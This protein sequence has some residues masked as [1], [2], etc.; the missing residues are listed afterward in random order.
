MNKVLTFII[1]KDEN[2]Q[3]IIMD[4]EVEENLT[5]SLIN[6]AGKVIPKNSLGDTLI[7]ISRELFQTMSN[8]KPMDLTSK[9]SGLSQAEILKQ[10]EN[11]IKD[12]KI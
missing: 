2:R 10:V 4:I 12:G 6:I 11:K 8:N 7:I 5:P 9:Y 1:A 3:N